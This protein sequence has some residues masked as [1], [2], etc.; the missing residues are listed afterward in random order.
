MD[1]LT[2]FGLL[3]VSLMLLFYFLE[4]RHP[5][6]SLAFGL[7]SWAAATYGWMA[8]VWPFAIVEL[9]WGAVAA[10]RYLARRRATR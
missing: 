2:A 4:P 10:R 5:I 6:Y 7:A 9:I 8:G 3:S 1:A